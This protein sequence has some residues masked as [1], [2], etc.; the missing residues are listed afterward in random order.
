LVRFGH[1]RDKPAVLL[2]VLS[3]GHNTRKTLEISWQCRPSSRCASSLIA[4]M[5]TAMSSG[6][7]KSSLSFRI[8]EKLS[9]ADRM[10]AHGSDLGQSLPTQTKLRCCRFGARRADRIEGTLKRAVASTSRESRRCKTNGVSVHADTPEP[11]ASLQVT[12]LLHRNSMVGCAWSSVHSMQAYVRLGQQRESI[13]W[14]ERAVEATTRLNNDALKTAHEVRHDADFVMLRSANSAADVVH[15]R[16][17]SSLASSGQ[18]SSDI[19]QNRSRL[20]RRKRE[21]LRITLEY[22][23]WQM[24]DACNSIGRAPARRTKSSTM[25]DKLF[26]MRTDVWGNTS[27]SLLRYLSGCSVM[28]KKESNVRSASPGVRNTE[29]CL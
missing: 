4:Q 19:S 20:R 26:A 6:R 2:C 1:A 7:A 23:R 9:S 11:I 10:G 13:S 29:G 5:M 28:S 18:S 16:G 15:R 14:V 25:D 21:N 3:C 17:K 8:A 24:L 12:R 22:Q 27:P